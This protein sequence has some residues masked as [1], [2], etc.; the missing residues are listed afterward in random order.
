M[1]VSIY[2]ITVLGQSRCV[3]QNSLQSADFGSFLTHY[4]AIDRITA[5]VTCR[6]D[7]NLLFFH[8]FHLN[9]QIWRQYKGSSIW[10]WRCYGVSSLSWF[11]HIGWVTSSCRRHSHPA[12]VTAASITAAAICAGTA[13]QQLWKKLKTYRQKETLDISNTAPCGFC[14]TSPVTLFALTNDLFSSRTLPEAP[15]KW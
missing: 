5:T 15:R 1:F 10:H 7:Q 14:W 4:V 2:W 8:P 13:A 11:S 9:L 12:H 6:I 3:L